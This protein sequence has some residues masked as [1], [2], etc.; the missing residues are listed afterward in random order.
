MQELE[1]LTDVYKG[2]FVDLFVRTG[3][4]VAINMYR[5]LGYSVFR[6]VVGYYS[7]PGGPKGDADEE[8]AFGKFFYLP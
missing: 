5:K 1:R 6:R 8:D 4:A 2:W 7:G 3:N